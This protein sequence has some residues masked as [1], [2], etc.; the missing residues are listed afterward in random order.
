[1]SERHLLDASAVLALLG[2][3]AGAH[4]VVECLDGARISA[5]NYSEV[6]GKLCE[7]DVP[8]DVV[9]EA[10][11][12]LKL[13]ILPFDRS[14]AEH[15]G[16]LRKRTRKLGLSFADRACLATGELNGF[17]VITADHSW[18]AAGIPVELIFIR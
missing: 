5:V 13:D 17:R 4:R 8:A 18:R 14:I 9:E 11:D 15:A 3:E 16:I 6:I 10:L 7:R 1:M 12:A 2:N